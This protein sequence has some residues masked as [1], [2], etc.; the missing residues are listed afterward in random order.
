MNLGSHSTL[1]RDLVVGAGLGLVAGIVLGILG[2]I[3]MRVIALRAGFGG[4]GS[5]G[6]TLEV[7]ATGVI[8]GGGAGLVYGGVRRWLPRGSM[9][10]GLLLGSGLTV[11]FWL[12][13][14]PAAR[15]AL[16]GT[17]HPG[18]ALGVFGICF[19]I[20]G[21]LVEALFSRVRRDLEPRG[22]SPAGPAE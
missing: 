17:G 10:R 14:P 15:S 5:L 3:A 11:F 19:V 12:Y 6:G 8:I 22:D 7:I 9:V 4:S 20:F 16:S 18:L 13:Q 21:F 2:R 1:G